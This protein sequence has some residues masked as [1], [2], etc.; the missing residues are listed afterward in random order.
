MLAD[1]TKT[2]DVMMRTESTRYELFLMD[3]QA[4]ITAYQDKLQGDG[5]WSYIEQVKQLEKLSINMNRRMLCYLFG[6][7]LG[8]HLA[9]KYVYECRS[10]LLYFLRQLTTEYR[11]FILYE[12]K[13]NKNLFANG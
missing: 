8:E 4:D 10:N 2:W 6:E 12:L 7:Q 1:Q 3:A 9:E 5:T 11:L 13:N